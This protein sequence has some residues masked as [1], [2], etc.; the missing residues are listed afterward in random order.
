M[1]E[2]TSASDAGLLLRGLHDA[3]PVFEAFDEKLMFEEVEGQA[4]T[5]AALKSQ[6]KGVFHN[7]STVCAQLR[8]TCFTGALLGLIP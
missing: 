5:H 4:S 7:I 1:V 3:G 6:F 8:I 2:S